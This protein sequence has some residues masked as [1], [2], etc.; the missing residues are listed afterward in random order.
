MKEREDITIDTYIN[1]TFRL[2]SCI[3]AYIIFFRYKKIYFIQ[4]KRS[5]RIKT[6]NFQA[7]KQLLSFRIFPF[8][9][10]KINKKLCP[11]MDTLNAAN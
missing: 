3:I 1:N 9:P 7:S 5:F 10:F 6:R 2:K 8:M 4:M 11:E